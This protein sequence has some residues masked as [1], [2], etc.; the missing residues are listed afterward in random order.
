M[1]CCSCKAVDAA[2][3]GCVP[4]S[5][6]LPAD[7]N[8]DI[9]TDRE[10]ERIHYLFLNNLDKLDALQGWYLHMLHSVKNT[11]GSLVFRLKSKDL[12]W[13]MSLNLNLLEKV[14]FTHSK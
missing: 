4:V 1:T 2:A 8:M 5:G 10:V 14:D 11:T 12:S 13:L 6:N 9:D 7:I 3:E